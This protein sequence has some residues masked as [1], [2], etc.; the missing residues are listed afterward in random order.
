MLDLFP[1]N[2]FGDQRSGPEQT[3]PSPKFYDTKKQIKT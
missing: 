3:S 1:E 2:D